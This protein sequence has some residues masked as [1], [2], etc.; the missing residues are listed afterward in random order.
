MYSQLPC[1]QC[2]VELQGRQYANEFFHC[3]PEHARGSLEHP[4]WKTYLLTF[5]CQ[6]WVAIR[7]VMSRCT[8]LIMGGEALP[9]RV[10]C[11][12]AVLLAD[13]IGVGVVFTLPGRQ[14]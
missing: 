10:P 12:S 6:H 13:D 14:C 8:H 1:N 5:S 2:I 9:Q 7:Y 3:H 11:A 4:H